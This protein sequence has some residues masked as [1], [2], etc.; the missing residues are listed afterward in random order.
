MEHEVLAEIDGVVRGLAV[1]VG[2]TVE[3]GQLLVTLEPGAA[4]SA[5][6][7]RSPASRAPQGERA[8]LRAVRERHEIGLDAARPEAVAR[9]AS[10]GGARRARTSRTCSTRAR[11][12]S[13]GR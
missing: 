7:A 3:E 6:A 12:S 13:T 11:S 10:A 9:A 5:D 8:D 2:D 4:A 1:A